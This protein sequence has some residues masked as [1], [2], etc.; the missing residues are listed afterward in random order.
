MNK[1]ANTPSDIL[2]FDP[3]T[4]G[5][6]VSDMVKT[7]NTLNAK[8]RIDIDGNSITASMSIP[9]GGTRVV[10]KYASGCQ[11]T[12]TTPPKLSIPERREMVKTL[13]SQGMKQAEMARRLGVCQKTISNDEKAN[14]DTL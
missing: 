9:D 14:K 5:F 10:K 13:R 7:C 1:N 3:A 8:A 12:F 6:D 11:E 2:P 4:F